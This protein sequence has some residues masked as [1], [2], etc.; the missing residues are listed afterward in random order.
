ML[1]YTGQRNFFRDLAGLSSADTT[2][3]TLADQLISSET[4]SVFN[5]R[6]WWFLQRTKTDTTV[7]SQENYKLPV[8]YKKLINTKVTSGS[9]DYIPREA[10][11]RAFFDELKSYGATTSTGPEWFYIYNGEILYF[12]KPSTSSLTITHQYEIQFKDQSRADYT[13]GTILSIANGATTVTGS[14]TS[15]TSA[16]AGRFIR[17]TE[18]DAAASGDNEWYEISTVTSST[19]LE[20]VKKYDGDTLSAASANYTIGQISPFPDG[21]HELP[22]YRALRIYFSTYKPDKTKSSLYREIADALL[23]QLITDQSHR[24][25]NMA[26]D[27]GDSVSSI[28]PNLTIT[29]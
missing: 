27:D 18:T 15:W 1:T 11:S 7:A 25:I 6:S 16:M 9:T 2:Q 12:P 8:F 28:N 23:A 21:Y 24:S 17:I 5:M 19:V 29:I 4:K 14:G 20:L 26:I 3:L 13:T 22:V 10:P